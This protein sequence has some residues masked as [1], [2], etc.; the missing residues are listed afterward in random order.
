MK[1]KIHDFKCWPFKFE[2][3]HGKITTEST[4]LSKQFQT[5]LTVLTGADSVAVAYSAYS[6]R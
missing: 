2:G 3:S 4:E 5:V 6:H 1:K